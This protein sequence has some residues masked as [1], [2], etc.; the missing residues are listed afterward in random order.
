MAKG[1]ALPNGQ[2]SNAGDPGTSTATSAGPSAS[3][4]KPDYWPMLLYAQMSAS[5]LRFPEPELEYAFASPRK[6][7]F[8]IAWPATRHAVEVDG[9]VH[10]I[11]S[12][13]RS[14]LEKSQAATLGGWR[15]LRVAP[16]QVKDGSALGLVAAF[17]KAG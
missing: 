5:P 14:D 16:R 12:R 11:K 17:L 9:A 8:D 15:V 2:T 1:S 4:S 6:W 10:R 7:R 13:F 3:A